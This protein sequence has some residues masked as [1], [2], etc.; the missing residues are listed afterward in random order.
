MPFSGISVSHFRWM[1]TSMHKM[2][3][4]TLSLS[5]S[6]YKATLCKSNLLEQVLPSRGVFWIFLFSFYCSPSPYSEGER[7]FSPPSEITRL[8]VVRVEEQGVKCRA[9]QCCW[10]IHTLPRWSADRLRDWE[11]WALKRSQGIELCPG[12]AH[13]RSL[14]DGLTLLSSVSVTVFCHPWKPKQHKN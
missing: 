11:A 10:Q 8:S 13:P 6:T 12:L 2:S 7:A 3:Q 5:L 14:S 1:G 4:V 9:G